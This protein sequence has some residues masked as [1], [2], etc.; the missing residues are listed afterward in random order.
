[1]SNSGAT[2]RLNI[3]Q[4]APVDAE[5]KQFLKFIERISNINACEAMY[6]Q[7]SKEFLRRLPIELVSVWVGE[8]DHVLCKATTAIDPEFIPAAERLERF[9]AQDVYEDY[10]LE[11]VIIDVLAQNRSVHIEDV[12]AMRRLAMS[13]KMQHMLD[14][15]GSPRT[16]LHLPI[17]YQDRPLAVLTLTSCKEIFRPTVDD[18]RTIELLSAFLG[19]LFI[20]VNMSVIADQQ[21]KKTEALNIQLACELISSDGQGTKDTLTDLY[22]FSYFYEALERRINEYFRDPDYDDVSI[23]LLELNYNHSFKDQQG[24]MADNVTIQEFARRLNMRIRNTDLACRFGRNEFAVLLSGCNLAH[25]HDFVDNVRKLMRSD[26]ITMETG[27][28]SVTINAGCAQ[29]RFDD[30]CSLLLERADQALQHAKRNG[31]PPYEI[32]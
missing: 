21:R 24:K 19:S 14:L 16:F 31:S 11:S 7:V 23:V 13:Q 4:S 5:Q 20:H 25:A 26:P 22:N 17:W 27:H 6:R 32:L 18:M 2:K 9:Y 3:F 30:S 12:S 10:D 15:I 28:L 8:G 29:C 1:M